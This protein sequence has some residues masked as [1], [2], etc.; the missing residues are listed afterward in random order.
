[1]SYSLFDDIKKNTLPLLQRFIKY[2]E[3]FKQ[4][5]AFV[6][7]LPATAGWLISNIIYRTLNCKVNFLIYCTKLTIGKIKC[8]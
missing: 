3:S 5:Q 4:N 7:L 1:M 6:V 2:I 8:H